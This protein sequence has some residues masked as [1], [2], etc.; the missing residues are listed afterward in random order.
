[1]GT[2]YQSPQRT[3]DDD[4]W[5]YLTPITGTNAAMPIMGQNSPKTGH[6]GQKRDNYPDIQLE[7]GDEYDYRQAMR[8]GN[9]AATAQDKQFSATKVLHAMTIGELNAL[10]THELQKY[11]RTVMD[12]RKKSRQRI[13]DGGGKKAQ[14]WAIRADEIDKILSSRKKA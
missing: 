8:A 3:Q 7:I 14:E 11:Q 1:M 13:G 4:G 12:N 9:E 5:D 10:P 6:A 2:P